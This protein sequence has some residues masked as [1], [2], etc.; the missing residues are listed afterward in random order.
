MT[1]SKV[2]HKYLIVANSILTAGFCGMI[3]YSLHH[4]EK[5]ADEAKVE[6]T[7]VRSEVNT[8]FTN[9]LAHAEVFEKDMVS[10]IATIEGCIKVLFNGNK[11]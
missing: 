9:H 10:R 3:L 11:R 4:I 6:V 8:Y 7:T 2:S 5:K 1:L